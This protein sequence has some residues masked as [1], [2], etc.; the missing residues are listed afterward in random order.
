M[1][2]ETY[3]YALKTAP[4]HELALSR[5]AGCRRFVFNELLVEVLWP[6]R[7][8]RQKERETTGKAITPYPSTYDLQKRLPALK[9]QYP[10]LKEPP[11]HTLQQAIV[12]LT[13]ALSRVKD[14]AGFPKLKRKGRSTDSCRES[15]KA[16]FQVDQNNSRIKIPK[17]GWV[18][19]HNSRL[20]EGQ[21][22]TLT[23][24][25]KDGRWFAS[26][27]VQTLQTPPDRHANAG[28]AVGIDRGI[29]TF[30]ALSDGSTIE[31]LSPLKA[32]L[33]ELRVAQRAVSRKKKG[34]KNRR[35]AQQRV[36]RIHHKVANIRRDFL[37][38]ASTTIAKNHGVVVLEKLD[39]TA[40]S[41]SATG[42]P[43]DPGKGVAR[44]RSLNRS[45]LDQGWYSFEQMLS[46]KLQKR[47]GQLLFV[48]AAYTSQRCSCCGH[49]AAENRT[50]QAAF[51]C[52][53]CGHTENADINAAKNILWAGHAHAGAASGKLKA[54]QPKNRRARKPA[55]S[56]P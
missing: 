52:V 42:S 48:P 45:I 53:S 2:V 51:C 32:A 54:N 41:R 50:S 12:D 27:Q 15:D 3:Q 35:R 56:Q 43:E 36:S 6:I 11:S 19:Y 33:R 30:A 7:A 47:G 37:H 55:R 1:L 39:V 25:R 5:W 20:F 44:K 14:G 4:R 21:A 18:R 31:S 29:A 46:Y 9:E 40:M 10:W 13:D 34:S 17:L 38:K 24:L 23:L 22:K 49:I 8:Q 28:S 16:C 26:I